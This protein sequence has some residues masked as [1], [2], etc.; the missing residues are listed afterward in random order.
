MAAALAA[1]VFLLFIACFDSRRV[2]RISDW[3]TGE[4]II[5]H[6]VS[7]GDEIFFGWIHS[8][9]DF[10]WNEIFIID[11]NFNLILDTVSFTE[12]GAGVPHNIGSVTYIKDGVIY[13][14]G[15]NQK[16]TELVW[17]NSAVATGEIRVAG[18]LV[19]RG[20]ELPHDRRL[21]L[22]VKRRN[23]FGK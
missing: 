5:E 8:L 16:F 3:K 21:V 2:V 11:G 12:F 19:T 14:S 7:P 20:Y 17:I 10:P 22:T 15:I 18:E 6:P 4:V 9:D 1:S 13:M 23:F